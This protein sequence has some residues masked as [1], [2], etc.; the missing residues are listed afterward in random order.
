[1]QSGNI[2]KLNKIHKYS[3]VKGERFINAVSKLK[4]EEDVIKRKKLEEIELKEKEE[5]ETKGA[6]G[7]KEVKKEEKKEVKKEV[8]KEEKK[9]VV[10]QHESKYE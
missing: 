1:M 7:K 2:K 8:K 4:Y 6:K 10:E 5:K 9:E 3:L